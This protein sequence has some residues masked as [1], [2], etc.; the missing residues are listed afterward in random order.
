MNTTGRDML[1][2]LKESF[3]LDQLVD[4]GLIWKVRPRDHFET[5][6]AWRT[7]CGRYPGNPA[8]HLHKY[9]KNYYWT[10]E[11]FGKKILC[12]RI[13]WMMTNDQLIPDKMVIDHWD[14]DTLCNYP[15]NLRLATLNDNARN[16]KISTQNTTGF[17]GVIFRPASAGGSDLNPYQAG[18]RSN[19]KT[20]HIGLFATPEKAHAAYM[21]EANKQYGE[22]SRNK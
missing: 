21:K 3:I 10:L 19:G 15:E 1:T 2:A 12:H 13:I 17:K 8:G 20:K 22:F 7:N 18:I 14:G 4:S 9:K 11:F 6:R 16:V 5:Y